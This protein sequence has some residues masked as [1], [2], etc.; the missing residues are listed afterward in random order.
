MKKTWTYFYDGSKIEVVNTWTGGCWL[1]INDQTQDINNGLI[2]GNL[3][4]NLENGDNILVTVGQGLFGIKCCL[5]VNNV[6]VKPMMINGKP[7]Q[8]GAM[9]PSEE[10]TKKRKN[11]KCTNCGA[12]VKS[13]TCEYCGEE[14]E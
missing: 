6:E 5:Y 1:L 4:A 7:T 8:S 10:M 9:V 14:V 11:I 13:D 3:R 12:K 2:S